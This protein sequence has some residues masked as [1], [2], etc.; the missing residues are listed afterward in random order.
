MIMMCTHTEKGAKAGFL[1]SQMC[2]FSYVLQYRFSYRNGE[3]TPGDLF[4]RC[5]LNK[6]ILKTVAGIQLLHVLS[7]HTP[8]LCSFAEWFL[9]FFESELTEPL[10]FSHYFSI[11]K[12]FEMKKGK[13]SFYW[14]F[15]SR[16]EGCS[17]VWW[18]VSRQPYPQLN[19]GWTVLH[20]TSTVLRR[21]KMNLG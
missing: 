2:M 21:S 16:G 9:H 10:N 15:R 6:Y 5:S 1:Q 3:L 4:P 17:T 20:Q 14:G 13:C 11:G 18:I 7:S 19:A 12:C 8:S